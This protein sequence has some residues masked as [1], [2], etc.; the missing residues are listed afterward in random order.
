MDFNSYERVRKKMG[1]ETI[2][3]F[4]IEIQIEY[5]KNHVVR[6]ELWI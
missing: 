6:G 2:C 1:L 4:E 5:K 3:G